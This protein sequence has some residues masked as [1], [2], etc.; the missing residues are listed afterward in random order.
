MKTIIPQKS[1]YQSVQES[2]PAKKV[3]SFNCQGSDT[4]Q[5]VRSDLFFYVK[6]FA[7]LAGVE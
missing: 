4:G 3:A 6:P 5:E 7:Y 1:D 2:T